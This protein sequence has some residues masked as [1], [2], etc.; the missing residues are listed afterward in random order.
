ML[1]L[2]ILVEAHALSSVVIRSVLEK[3]QFQA[4]VEVRFGVVNKH[5]I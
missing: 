3:P 2:R 5:F 4:R 1:G